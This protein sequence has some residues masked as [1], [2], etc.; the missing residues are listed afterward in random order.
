MPARAERK[1]GIER[2]IDRAASTRLHHHGPPSAGDAQQQRANCA[3]RLRDPS[4]PA[5]AKV[6]A[7]GAPCPT[8]P[9]VPARPRPRSAAGNRANRFDGQR[10]PP[11]PVRRQPHRS[12]FCWQP[13]CRRACRFQQRIRRRPRWTSPGSRNRAR[14]EGKRGTA[15]VVIR[16]PGSQLPCSSRLARASAAFLFPDSG[17]SRL[18]RGRNFFIEQ[19]L[20]RAQRECRSR[21]LDHHL[22][23]RDAHPRDRLLPRLRRVGDDLADHRVVVRRNEVGDRCLDADAA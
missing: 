6:R 11:H 14:Y 1:A 5:T 2:E 4:W 7:A 13:P 16:V 17:S 3:W 18:R 23:Q 21:S 10:G 12:P 20:L 22:G 19:K 15:T 8:R 9:D